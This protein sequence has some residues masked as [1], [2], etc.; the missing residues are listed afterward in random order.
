MALA[1][2]LMVVVAVVVEMVVACGVSF[3]PLVP[4]RCP[5]SN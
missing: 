2:E 5:A 4:L 1:V 3:G